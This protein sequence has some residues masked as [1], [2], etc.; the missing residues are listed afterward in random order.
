M[1][2]NLI[3]FLLYIL[4]INSLTCPSQ[5]P[6]CFNITEEKGAAKFVVEGPKD[7]GYMALGLGIDMFKCEMFVAYFDAKNAPQLI[8]AKCTGYSQPQ[9]VER[10]SLVILNDESYLKGDTQRIVFIRNFTTSDDGSLK[11]NNIGSNEMV[12]AYSNK[13]PTVEKKIS[14]HQSRGSILYSMESGNSKA[15][16]PPPQLSI[17]I[18]GVLMMVA[19]LILPS[20]AIFIARFLK[21]KLG[22]WWFK[23]HISA[24]VGVGVLSAISIA[25]VAA[26]IGNRFKTNHSIIGLVVCGLFVMQCSLGVII[27]K[28][29]SSDR[30]HVPIQDKIHWWLGRLTCGLSVANI[31]YG[32]ILAQSLAEFWIAFSSISIIIIF[33]FM[34]GHFLIGKI[35][36]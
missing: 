12:W 22:V 3:I 29:W 11:I 17:L 1:I 18:H 6:F 31:I 24:F 28:L 33:G 16:Q 25:I 32:I 4:Q 21:D 23:L 14:K 36:H 30:K 27:D 20:L 34:S 26:K 9:G 5:A 2:S 19:W 13:K 10:S 7:A 8:H 15:V 35:N